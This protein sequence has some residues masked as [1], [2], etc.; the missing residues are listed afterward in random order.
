MSRDINGT[1]T[2]PSG[3]PVVSGT[4]ITSTPWGNPTFSDIAT[5]LTDSLSRTGNGG[6]I[7]QFQ[8]AAGTVSAPGVGFAAQ[9][10]MGMYR[11]GT[12]EMGVTVAGTKVGRWNVAGLSVYPDAG[13]TAYEV[14]FRRLPLRAVTGADST[15]ATDSGK[16]LKYTGSTATLTVASSTLIALDVVTIVNAGTGVL[17][18]AESLSGTMIW[19]DAAG[20]ASVGSRDLAI[21]GVATVYMVDANNAYIWGNGIS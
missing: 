5:A 2:L 11:V 19:M 12:N 6:M 21:G 20:L 1:Y 17:T 14:G 18:I 15:V 13:S 3:N 16:L 9:T 8:L 7:S 4:T 10:N